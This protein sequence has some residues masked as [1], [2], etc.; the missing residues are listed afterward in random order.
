MKLSWYIAR[1]YL[2]ARSRGR[3]LSFITW[4]ALGGVTVGV[5]ALVLVTG[6]MTGMQNEL[7]EKILGVVPHVVVEEFSETLRVSD[8]IAVAELIESVPGV[9]GVSPFA[10]TSIALVTDSSYAQAASLWGVNPDST[11]A[12]G[13]TPLERDIQRGRYNLEREP[14]SDL[15][16]ILLGSRLAAR[17][18]LF[19]GD[20]ITV[21]LQE[22]PKISAFGLLPT[23]RQFV[24]SGLVTTG[25]FEY[26]RKYAYIALDVAQ[27]LLGLDDGVVSGLGVSTVDASDVV[28]VSRD[29]ESVLGVRYFTTDWMEQNQALFA[30]LALEKLAMGII[31]FLIVVVAAFNIV[32]TLVM[33]VVDRTREIGILKSMGMTNDGVLQIFILQGAWIGIVGTG[34]GTIAGMTIGWTVDRFELIKIPP[35]VYF[36]DRLPVDMRPTDIG[37]IVLASLVVAFAATIYPAL[38]ASRLS[39]VEAI[40][41][42]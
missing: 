11:L 13:A 29:I 17:M 20:T 30:A 22:L 8:W 7:R 28:R 35:G 39:P 25:M 15:Y 1:H 40:R 3:L 21:L 31:L 33:V 23:T 24:V 19:V 14:G 12:R 16:P 37:L 32:S 36:V 18:S 34:I 42:E 4:V 6:V 27:E 41:H 9:A 5:T 2:L 26:D 38:Q 10:L